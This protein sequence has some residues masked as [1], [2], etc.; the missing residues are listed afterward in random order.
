MIKTRTKKIAVQI[1]KILNGY[2]IKCEH[3]G[4]YNVIGFESEAK[5]KEAIELLNILKLEEDNKTCEVCNKIKP[6][7]RFEGS[8]EKY[9]CDNCLFE[10][11]N[12]EKQ[13][14]TGDYNCVR[15]GKKCFD[16]YEFLNE[17]NK[18]IWCNDCVDILC[19]EFQAKQEIKSS[20][21]EK[22]Q[23]SEGKVFKVDSVN[24]NSN[25]TKNKIS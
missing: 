2:G 13:K 1:V 17:L 16:T 22:L 8:E 4:Y 19:K 20:V 24:S 5:E 15:C 10:I 9:I 23:N 7:V 6:D 14:V 3:D 21:T 12:G 11:K 25:R 18:R